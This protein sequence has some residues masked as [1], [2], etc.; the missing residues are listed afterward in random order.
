[1]HFAIKAFSVFLFTAAGVL[2]NTVYNMR[3]I[4]S[5]E[6]YLA[7]RKSKKAHGK[8]LLEEMKGKH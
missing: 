5:F 2:A 6:N 1:M 7:V 3:E 4:E 8:K